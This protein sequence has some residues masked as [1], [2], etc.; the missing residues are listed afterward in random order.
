MKLEHGDVV[1]VDGRA[2]QMMLDQDEVI[3]RLRAENA[4]LL[5]QSGLATVRAEEA[6]DRVEKA[7]RELERR[8]VQEAGVST[9]LYG[10]FPDP[11]VTPDDYGWSINYDDAKRLWLEREEARRLAERLRS[12]SS[13]APL[14]WEQETTE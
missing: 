13:W 10:H 2:Y 12:P 11:H 6:E 9:A 8:I 5:E 7:E 3:A 1:E 14:P 4:Q